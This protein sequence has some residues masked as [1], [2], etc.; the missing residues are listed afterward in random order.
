MKKGRREKAC[1]VLVDS[2]HPEEAVKD[3]SFASF[4]DTITRRRFLGIGLT[5]TAILAVPGSILGNRLGDLQEK[6]VR[7]R[8]LGVTPGTM[9][10]GTF[11]AITDVAGV[12]VGYTTLIRGKGKLVVGD[13]PV[14]TGVTAILPVGKDLDVDLFA[15]DL[16]LNGNGE[17]TGIGYIRRTGRLGGPILLTNT[18]NIGTV[19]DSALSWMVERRP[20]LMESGDW[21]EPVVGETWDAFLNDIEGR[22][23]R[24]EHVRSAIETA[25]SGLIAEGCVGGGTGM[26]SYGFKGGTGTSS[27]RFVTSNG[28]QYT[29]GV[30]VQANHGRRPQLMILGVPVGREIPDRTPEPG[31]SRSKSILVVIATD[32]PLLP[33]QL[34]RLAK[35]AAMGLARTGSLSMH[36]SGDLALAFSTGNL[37]PLRTGVQ[38]S[39]LKVLDDNAINP[40]YQATI[41]ATEE[42]V[43]NALTAAT[44]MTGR[45]DN[46]VHALPL[47][48]LLKVFRT[49]NKLK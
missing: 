11:N 10:P 15:G 19:Y 34:R 33:V 9:P 2:T 8:Q 42:A 40:V 46:T 25:T 26:I 18:S 20:G 35:R 45:D 16:T 38:A 1:K 3:N 44:T 13:G 17:M 7:L 41:E 29:V 22:H 47:D 24:S 14:R 23:V 37:L 6:R 21:P 5:G 39:E 30:L 32:A 27:R 43:L 4:T 12:E 31:K 48:R 36:S 49:Y 28:V